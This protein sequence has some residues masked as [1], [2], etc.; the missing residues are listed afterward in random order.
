MFRTNAPEPEPEA[1]R[2]IA[3]PA[4]AGTAAAVVARDMAVLAAEGAEAMQEEVSEADMSEA[5]ATLV[6]PALAGIGRMD[7]RL[8]KKQADPTEEL[9]CGHIGHDREMSVGLAQDVARSLWG[10][11]DSAEEWSAGMRLYA[12]DVFSRAGAETPDF[13]LALDGVTAKE[14]LTPDHK[15]D[16]YYVFGAFLTSKRRAE[17]FSYYVVALEGKEW[18]H[19]EAGRVCVLQA[20]FIKLVR[21]WNKALDDQKRH[22]IPVPM[23]LRRQM[24]WHTGEDLSD[25]ESESETE[26]ESAEESS[27]EW[28][29]TEDSDMETE[30]QAAT[31]VSP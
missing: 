10:I 4:A 22:M 3:E 12:C 31:M 5:E 14:P 17:M 30:E 23:E 27:S 11:K 13:L 20:N 26:S 29:G 7:K 21:A 6:L 25:S 19:V 18:E 15:H 8:P 16:D 28:E 2:A 1:D 9:S 24:Q